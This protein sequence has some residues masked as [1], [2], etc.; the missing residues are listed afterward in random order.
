MKTQT[1]IGIKLVVEGFHRFPSATKYFKR[2][3]DFL[4]Q[5]HRHNF[6]ICAKKKVYSDERDDEFILW[7]R[8]VENYIER[9][10]GRPAEFNAMSCEAIARDILEA[11]DCEYVAVDEDGENFAEIFKL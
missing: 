3:V 9:N 2:D 8:E 10:Y 7:K 6:G 4:E 11:F 5:R 1:N